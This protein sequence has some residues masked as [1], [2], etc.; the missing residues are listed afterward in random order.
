[1]RNKRI[2][3]TFALVAV[4]L[5]FL[6]LIVLIGLIGNAIQNNL[7]ANDRTDADKIQNRLLIAIL[8]IASAL[9]IFCIMFFI[10]YMRVYFSSSIRPSVSR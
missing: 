4:T 8:S 1:M 10:I 5:A 7:Y 6:F 2:T 9:I 3:A